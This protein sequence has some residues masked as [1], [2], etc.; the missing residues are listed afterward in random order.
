MARR[1][2]NRSLLLVVC[3][4]LLLS[5][6][7]LARF[8]VPADAT[9][10]KD[11]Q[12]IVSKAVIERISDG[13]NYDDVVAEL[14]A[15]NETL[16]E[17]L[18][19][20]KDDLLEQKL[21]LEGQ[22]A[23]RKK[24]LEDKENQIAS[25]DAVIADNQAEIKKSQAEAQDLE[26]RRKEIEQKREVLLQTNAA[27]KKEL[28][29]L[30]L[31]LE[32]AKKKSEQL[33]KLKA[34]TEKEATSFRIELA[35]SIEKVKAEEKA[36]A[37]AQE[38]LRDEKKRGDALVASNAKIDEKFDSLNAGLQGV[39]Q[40]LKIVGQGL[41]GVGDKITSVTEEVN[42]VKQDVSRVGLEIEG[43]GSK[44]ENIK[45][46]V[47]VSAAEQKEN[48]K[49]LT[50]V[51]TKSFNEIFTKYDENKI[52][53]ELTF[54][55]KGGFMGSLK[56]ETF[57][58]DTIIMVDGSFA[59]SLVHGKNTPFRLQPFPRKLTEVSGQITNPKL[60]SSIQVKE[61]AFM[62]D[63]RILIVPLYIKPSEL[64]KTS[65]IEVFQAP[66]NPY[67][68]SEAVVVNSKDGRFG[69]TDFIRDERDSRYIK[70]SHTNF[71]FITGKF[72]PGKGDLVFSQK[73]ELLGI[74]VNNDYA[75]HVKNLGS[76]IHN[77]SRTTLGLAFDSTKAN[78]LLSSLNKALSGLNKKFR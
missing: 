42:S 35:K 8:D 59:Y 76:R 52:R 34:K 18:S 24:E 23:Q 74:M 71:A 32:E 7:A 56:K 43:V 31:N 70:V 20:D 67:L 16:L 66:K 38:Q 13:E 3:D 17:N 68:F 4:F 11:G 6:L 1:G 78:P 73:G 14:E 36:N 9:I 25:R 60:K 46:D 28:E 29:L 72:D 65:D 21:K 30:A 54:T 27:S 37:A 77:G 58:M 15:T 61:V 2:M 39:G 55:H 10:A 64:E 50:D 19:S 63:P 75:F 41:A 57:E 51:Q 49:K 5:I 33:A 47:A 40:D 45:N 22:I 44:V 48:F 26:R 12:K 53:L 69:Q 62:D